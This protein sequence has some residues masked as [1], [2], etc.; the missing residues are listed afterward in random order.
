[1]SGLGG[2]FWRYIDYL[3]NA[4]DAVGGAIRDFSDQT[5][6]GVTKGMCR[7]I[8]KYPR[9]FILFPYSRALLDKVCPLLDE[10]KPPLPSLPFTGGQCC[11]TE[12]RV[13]FFAD[14][15]VCGTSFKPG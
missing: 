13:E 15:N 1:M 6:A 2:Y 4:G 7:I 5:G 14:I 10:E 8:N 9:N 12:Y 3:E 11:D